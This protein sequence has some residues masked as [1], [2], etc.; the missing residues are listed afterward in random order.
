M[1]QDMNSGQKWVSSIRYLFVLVPVSLLSLKIKYSIL[2]FRA[3]EVI[4]KSI[5]GIG[6]AGLDILG[7]WDKLSLFRGDIWVSFIVFPVCCLLITRMLRRRFR[8]FVIAIPNILIFFMLFATWQCHME[9]GRYYSIATFLDSLSWA[10]QNP[11]AAGDYVSSRAM[12]QI[13]L[14]ILFICGTSLWAAILDKRDAGWPNPSRLKYRLAFY[15][16][17]ILF[18]AVLPSFGSRLP[19]TPY[20][21]S[22]LIASTQAFWEIGGEALPMKEYAGLEREELLRRYNNFVHAPRPE[23]NPEFWGKAKG[24]NVLFFILETAPTRIL[25]IEGDLRDLPVLQRL[26]EKAFIG[27]LHHTTYPYSSRAWFSIF[28]SL[29]PSSLLR[30]FG[31]K[32]GLAVP[33]IMRLLSSMGYNSKVY[34]APLGNDYSVFESLGI[35]SQYLQ[36]RMDEYKKTTSNQDVVQ[37]QIG[38][39]MAALSCLKKDI[40]DWSKKG[41]RFCVAVGPQISH[42]PWPELPG[43]QGQSDLIAR[44]RSTMVLQ[45]KWLGELLNF[46]EEHDQLDKTILVLTADH[47]VRTRQEDIRFEGSMIDEYSFH[48]PL[49]IYAPGVLRSTVSIPWLTSHIDISP[50]VLELLGIAEGRSLEQGSPIW[51]SQLQNRVTYFFANHFLGADGYMF[52]GTYYMRSQVT[53][54]V[55]KNDRL[56]FGPANVIPLGSPEH[57]RIADNIKHMI[58]LQE[59]LGKTLKNPNSK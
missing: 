39:D 52:K 50:T 9:T 42:G 48:V 57:E 51:N 26:R 24:F 29:Y 33:S 31:E 56:K 34:Y 58:A 12:V 22:V 4:S 16:V 18:M 17:V 1:E 23:R 43:S 41:Q 47:G 3:I 54:M 30:N 8:A 38:E 7:V 20:H 21:K 36:G 11:R 55:Y 27:S 25:R 14:A 2:T 59:A 45:D 44:G 13:A 37:L 15:L 49:L 32:P 28:S 10:L 40:E 46:L 35:G 5:G 53:D 6:N 19:S